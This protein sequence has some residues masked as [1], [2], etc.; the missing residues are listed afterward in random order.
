MF[1]LIL[2]LSSLLVLTIA[3]EKSNNLKVLMPDAVATHVTI[4]FTDFFSVALNFTEKKRISFL[5]RSTIIYARRSK[6]ILKIRP[7]SVGFFIIE[8]RTNQIDVSSFYFSAAFNPAATSKDAHHILL[9]GCSEPGSSQKIWF[10]FLREKIIFF[11]LFS[12]K[13]RN[14]GEMSFSD[15]QTEQIY[16]TG[17][18]CSRGSTIIFAWALDAEKTEL[19]KGFL[20]RG[21]LPN[22]EKNKDFLLLV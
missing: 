12:S 15:D 13:K 20:Q 1:S 19:P 3:N 6:W 16:E 17:P 8:N 2:S 10:V 14:C 22:K 4:I 7:T 21:I 9:F 5:F 18:T 11:E